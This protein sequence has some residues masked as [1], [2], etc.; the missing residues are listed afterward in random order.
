M[1]TQQRMS[2]SGNYTRYIP[3]MSINVKYIFC[4]ENFN[5]H[6]RSSKHLQMIERIN[7]T[8]SY[9]EDD[10]MNAGHDRLDLL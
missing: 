3:Y 6:M 1:V 7:K 10:F 9:I 5:I 2:Y 8:E 4:S